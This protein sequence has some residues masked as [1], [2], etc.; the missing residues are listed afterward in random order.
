MKK[1]VLAVIISGIFVVYSL[2]LRNQHS[3]AVI[4]PASIS[5]SNTSGGASGSSG[6][7]SVSSSSGSGSSGSTSTSSGT[8]SSTPSSQ[9]K[10]GTYTGDAEN[11]FYGNVQ[12]SATISGG[13]ITSVDF[14]QS[15][16]EN[17]NSQSINSQA[18]PYLKQEA[19]QAQS[20]NVSGVTGAT[21]TSQAFIQS[22][23]SALQQ[24]K[25]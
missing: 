8:G 1:F 9:Y 21:L 16:N 12:V 13:K 25:S 15:P 11:A 5:K 22:L 2:V 14:L 18:I 19:I 10:D 20:A 3:G 24:A 6:S 7:S 23:G 4:A 17:P